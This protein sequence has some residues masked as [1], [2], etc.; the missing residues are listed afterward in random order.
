MCWAA[1]GSIGMQDSTAQCRDKGAGKKFVLIS[2]V[3]QVLRLSCLLIISDIAKKDQ[4]PSLYLNT[5][6]MPTCKRY[7]PQQEELCPNRFR[8]AIVIERVQ[9]CT[10]QPIK[11]SVLMHTRA[12]SQGGNMFQR[13]AP[14]KELR[15]AFSPHRCLVAAPG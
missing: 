1:P 9:G 15:N 7:R 5:R 10:Y 4:S 13:A 12:L 14:Q 2:H 3:A 6:S 8:G 11:W